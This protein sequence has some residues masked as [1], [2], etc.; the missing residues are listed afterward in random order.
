MGKR[1]KRGARGEPGAR[2]DHERAVQGSSGARRGADDDEGSDRTRGGGE[3]FWQGYRSIHHS[4]QSTR[5][6][7]ARFER[8]RV[9]GKSARRFFKWVG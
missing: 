2:R 9:R 5:R 7:V 3:S 6:D 1:R 8:T 4:S